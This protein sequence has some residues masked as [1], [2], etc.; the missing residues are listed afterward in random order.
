MLRSA[1]V[2]AAVYTVCAL[3]AALLTL[4]GGSA[5]LR[6]RCAERQC[7]S[8]GMCSGELDS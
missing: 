6:P 8:I 4:A 1:A 3:A 7:S 2:A 5:M